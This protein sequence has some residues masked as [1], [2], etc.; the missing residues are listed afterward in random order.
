MT[1]GSSEPISD[2]SAPERRHCL[3]VV[4]DQPA[5]VQTR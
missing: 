2:G 1:P 4:D 5:N 3:L